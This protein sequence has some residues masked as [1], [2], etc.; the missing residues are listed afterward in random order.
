MLFVSPLVLS[1]AQAATSVVGCVRVD[2]EL[3]RALIDDPTVTA[4]RVEGGPKALAQALDDALAV[5][6]QRRVDRGALGEQARALETLLAAKGYADASVSFREE[7]LSDCV[8]EVVFAID[9]G[10]RVPVRSVR[11]DGAPAE[12]AGS[13]RRALATKRRTSLAA[14]GGTGWLVPS[15]VQA[16]RDRLEWLLAANGYLEAAVEPA[17]VE[18]TADGATV[19]W[20]VRPASKAHVG[21]VRFAGE[22]RPEEGLGE[23]ALDELV[24]GCS[25]REVQERQWREASGKRPLV[26]EAPGLRAGDVASAPA[27]WELARSAELLAGSRGYA[28]QVVP[29]RVVHDGLADITLRV[30]LGERLRVRRVRFVGNSVAL[31]H[32]LRRELHVAEGA[33]YNA[34]EVD[35]MRRSLLRSGWFA[36]VE[37]TLVPTGEP[38]E[39]DLEVQVEEAKHQNANAGVSTDPRGRVGAQGTYQSANIV[40]TGL[41]GSARL[42]LARQASEA[43]LAISEPSVLDS[44]WSASASAYRTHSQVDRLEQR[45]GQSLAIGRALDRRGDVRLAGSL[46][47]SEASI[48]GL[49][50]SQRRLLGGEL[51]RD[52]SATRLGLTLTVDERDDHVDPTAGWRMSVGAG[53]TGGFGLANGRVLELLPGDTHLADLRA[54]GAALHPI[55]PALIARV[56]GEARVVQATD[57]RVTPATQLLRLGGADGPRGYLPLSLGPSARTL[58]STDPASADRT[59]VIGG[60]TSVS[61][62]AE[63]QLRLAPRAGLSAIGFV[64][65]AAVSGAPKGLD[66]PAAFGA[67]VGVGLEWSRSPF[68]PLRL[69]VGVPLEGEDHRPRVQVGFGGSF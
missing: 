65:A 14:L 15:E 49:D 16:D 56:R 26:C 8:I 46:G 3:V 11:V 47:W 39:V 12:L 27:L 25:A 13:L 43:Q 23:E 33:T 6:L 50:A 5:P 57:G 59:Q 53:L 42:N 66:A 30:Q 28:A 52:T 67:S 21:V 45:A 2:E 4:A 64:D 60:A 69:S 32:T 40:G 9:A 1:L 41:S 58:A 37:V 18:R 20:A 61:A 48:K 22:L 54:A 38:G 31:D 62:S 68:G 7:P 19:R 34:D 35:A 29:E 10:S 24:R 17:H 63:L 51:F 36:S 55:T 44:P